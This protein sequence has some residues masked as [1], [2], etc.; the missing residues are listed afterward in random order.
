MSDDIM[1]H[2]VVVGAGLAGLLAATRL[3]RESVP[4]TC[5]YYGIG[6]LPA[7]PG[8]G[9]VYGYNDE[10]VASPID[11]VGRAPK[12]H[13]YG[14]I[15]KAA[16]RRGLELL[17]ELVGPRLLIGDA[18]SNIC[19]P[20]AMGAWRPTC[21]Y[22]PSMA[23]GVR[24]IGQSDQP[25]AAPWVIVGFNTLKDFSPALVAGNLAAQPGPDGRPMTVRSAMVNITVRPGEVDTSPMI[26]ARFFDTAQGRRQLVASLR[27]VVRQEET[28]GLPAVLGLADPTAYQAISDMLHQPVFEIP[29]PPPSVPGWRINNAL[30][31]AAER[32]GVRFW[33]GARV[34]RL[35]HTGEKVEGVI[36]QSAGH[37]ASEP[38]DAVVLATGGLATGGLVIDGQNRVVEPLCNL[39]L[40]GVPSEL[41]NDD[42]LSAQPAWLAGVR[43][44]RLMRPLDDAG[45]VVSPNLY[46]VGG[47][48]AGSVRWD[49]KT[50]TGVS[51][52]S[53]V[54]AAEAIIKELA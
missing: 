17:L 3:A 16:T 21:L 18:Q 39:P 24:P 51:A 13:P 2:V 26:F 40:A 33:R 29:L 6:G 15:G 53:A 54:A 27:P 23:A 41:F 30:F 9:D 5:V 14:P 45:N 31:A 28:I 4:V 22:Q 20:T 49:E 44:D 36:I 48:L 52:G 37:T 19:L 43:V 47:L 8:V 25:S 34:I 11:A 35:E 50:T 46:A 42:P 7:S 12:G 38:V 10:I 1:H 32:A